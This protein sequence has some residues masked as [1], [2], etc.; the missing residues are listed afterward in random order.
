MVP[1]SY[2]LG[3]TGFWALSWF[4]FFLPEPRNSV[5]L[6]FLFRSTPGI[7]P[8]L[9]ITT[10]STPAKAPS[11]LTCSIATA[12][13]ESPSSCFLTQSDHHMWQEWSLWT[14]SGYFT[15]VFVIHQGYL[16]P[17]RLNLNS[18]LLN[19]KMLQKLA[20]SDLHQPHVFLYI[21][22]QVALPVLNLCSIHLELW[23][24]SNVPS[25]HMPGALYVLYCL[26]KCFPLL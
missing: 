16:S 10:H 6:L 26:L 25:S 2:P 24:F 23:F 11:P 14:K 22:L 18:L 17:L 4:L 13:N 15:V 20:L 1:P 3:Q 19:Y 7:P 8:S 21:L 5:N 12:S 9:S